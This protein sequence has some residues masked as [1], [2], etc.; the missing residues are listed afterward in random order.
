LNGLI[1]LLMHKKLAVTVGW[2]DKTGGA[3]R[4]VLIFFATFLYQDKKV[5]T[6]F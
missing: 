2:L 6:L 1:F 5:E 3:I 4:F